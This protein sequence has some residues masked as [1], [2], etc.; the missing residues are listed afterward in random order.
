MGNCVFCKIINKK[1]ESNIT[2]ETDNCLALLAINPVNVGHALVIS[3][4]HFESV[5]DT[6]NEVLTEM[7]IAAKKIGEIAK[8]ELG[9]TAYNILNASGKDAQQSVFHIHFHVV[10][11]FPDDNLDLWLNGEGVHKIET[12]EVFDRYIKGLSNE[13]K[14]GK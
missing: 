4:S 12:R 11:R 6:P 8:R 3:K 5:S 14:G 2:L 9:A 7:I 10:P 1:M 13:M